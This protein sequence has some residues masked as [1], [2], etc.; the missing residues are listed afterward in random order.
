MKRA[1]HDFFALRRDIWLI[2]DAAGRNRPFPLPNGTRYASA[3]LHDP[4][5]LMGVELHLETRDWAAIGVAMAVAAAIAAL[6]ATQGLAPP[7]REAV[8][9]P[10]L[11]AEDGSAGQGIV[12][13][14]VKSASRAAAAGIVVGDR[15]TAIDSQPVPTLSAARRYIGR[16]SDAIID[17]AVDHNHA[18]RTIRFV[19]QGAVQK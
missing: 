11:T 3:R 19:R 12:V 15:I 2:G 16:D 1:S 17:M 18:Q 9:M 6:A 14:S 7:H 4:P 10:G 13:T 5:P 8:V